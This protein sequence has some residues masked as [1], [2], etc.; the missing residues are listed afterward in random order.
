MSRGAFRTDGR[1]LFSLALFNGERKE[2]VALG[3][4]ADF[5]ERYTFFI[6]FGREQQLQRIVAQDRT[7][8]KF[9]HRQSLIEDLERRLL[10]FSFKDMA[11]HEHGLALSFGPQV[12]KSPLG[13]CR[14]GKLA[15]LTAGISSNGGHERSEWLVDLVI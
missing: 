2:L 6:D 1:F 11:D 8:G 3:A 15:A 13:L 10:P 14:A 12:P 5:E 7:V 4:R 9:D